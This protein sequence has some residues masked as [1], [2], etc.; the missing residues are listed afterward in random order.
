MSA[1]VLAC[2]S[3]KLGGAMSELK[4]CFCKYTKIG[5]NH[6]PRRWNV[7]V[8]DDLHDKHAWSLERPMLQTESSRC[9]LDDESADMAQRAWDERDGWEWIRGET[10]YVLF[11]PEGEIGP[12]AAYEVS[13]DFS[14]SFYG[15][16]QLVK[17]I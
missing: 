2:M 14:P 6:Q 9:R 11:A 10:V 13:V 7:W 5:I 4:A 3:L 17:E 1:P 15:E 16:G 12:P 8:V